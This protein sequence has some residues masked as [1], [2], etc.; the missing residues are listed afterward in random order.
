L[1]PIFG[2]GGTPVH[3]RGGY[4]HLRE[5]CFSGLTGLTDECGVPEEQVVVLPASG[6]F[7]SDETLILKF[8][9]VT[10]S[11]LSADSDFGAQGRNRW[12]GLP[13]LAGE[14]IQTAVNDLR[15]EGQPAEL[16]DGLGYKDAVEEP[17]RVEGLAWL[18]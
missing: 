7:G 10:P 12:V 13:V 4:S 1:A 11:L 3:G 5:G 16:A 2:R 9:D 15:T 8:A 14:A 18:K 17:I 6:P